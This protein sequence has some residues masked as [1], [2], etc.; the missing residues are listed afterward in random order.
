[1]KK[2]IQ[3][4]RIKKWNEKRIYGQFLRETSA[5]VDRVK[6]EMAEKRRFENLN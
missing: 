5:K 3:D 4:E 1:M 2:N 6:L